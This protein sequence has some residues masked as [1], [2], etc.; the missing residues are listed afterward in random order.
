MFLIKIT[1][2]NASGVAAKIATVPE[3]LQNAIATGLQRG[4]LEAA[5]VTQMEFLSG[6]RP[7]KLDAVTT[8]LRN[9]IVTEVT[10]TANTIIG[11]EG[12]NVPYAAIHEF[13]FHGVVNVKAFTRV[14][15][16]SFAGA[17][18]S[19]TYADSV[20]GTRKS[21]FNDKG[22]FQGFAESRKRAA[23]RQRTGS[24]GIQF[25]KAHTRRVDYAGKPFIRPAIEQ[26]MPLILG[27]INKEV[28]AI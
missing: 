23:G 2:K 5:R 25:V 28:A 8:R 26:S 7:S 22:E 27:E 15:D 19:D 16:Q 24:V 1:E 10:Q 11:R 18:T 6:P 17:K 13:G 14:T 4:L 20:R 9:S 21:I 3:R 12:T